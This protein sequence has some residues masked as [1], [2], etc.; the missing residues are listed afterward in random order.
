[1]PKT[2]NTDEYGDFALWEAECIVID[3]KER[4]TKGMAELRTA[5]LTPVY[6]P[7]YDLASYRQARR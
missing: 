5:H 2:I 3:E 4:I 1:M 6:A 7:V